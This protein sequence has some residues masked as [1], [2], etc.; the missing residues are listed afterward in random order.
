MLTDHYAWGIFGTPYATAKEFYP[1]ADY[2]IQYED[3]YSGWAPSD[4]A[5]HLGQ[6]DK[7][8]DIWYKAASKV[9]KKEESDS[10]TGKK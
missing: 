6:Y 1:D 8:A 4:W 9:L 7:N 2:K 5:N 3:Q 10:K